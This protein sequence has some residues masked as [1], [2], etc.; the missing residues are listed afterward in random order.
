M[1]T[2]PWWEPVLL[3]FF[4][5]RDHQAIIRLDFRRCR[6]EKVDDDL[7]RNTAKRVAVF[8]TVLG[9]LTQQIRI[10]IRCKHNFRCGR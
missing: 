9:E 1:R 3:L 10:P 6:N 7:P 5:I 2:G 8:M 4:Q